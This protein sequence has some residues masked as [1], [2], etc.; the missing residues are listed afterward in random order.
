MSRCLNFLLIF[1]EKLILTNDLGG[2]A[3][4][5]ACLMKLAESDMTRARCHEI[6]RLRS[7]VNSDFCTLQWLSFRAVHKHRWAGVYHILSYI[8]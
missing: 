1:A 6:M 5:S 3:A 7:T 4:A 2:Q 8:L